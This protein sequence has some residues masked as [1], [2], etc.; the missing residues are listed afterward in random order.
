MT[1]MTWLR[2]ALLVKDINANNRSLHAVVIV[3]CIEFGRIDWQTATQAEVVN[4]LVAAIQHS[5]YTDVMSRAV[6]TVTTEV[7]SITE[8]PT[9]MEKVQTRTVAALYR[10]QLAA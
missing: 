1:F 3:V 8:W 6:R 7:Y 2:R 4:R 9:T 10:L 5:P